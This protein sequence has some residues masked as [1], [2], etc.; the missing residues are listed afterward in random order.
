LLRR[1]DVEMSDNLANAAE[2]LIDKTIEGMLYDDKKARDCRPDAEWDL[3][4]CKQLALQYMNFAK[5]NN[6]PD[7]YL[8]E[9]RDW[10]SYVDDELGLTM[11]P[12]APMPGLGATATPQAGP[13]PTPQ[14][15][16]IPNVPGLQGAI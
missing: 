7:K 14:S 13:M 6:C 9:L 3:Q 5:L 8:N 1:P 4:L 16:M 11:P 10:M 2:E 12:P 15:E